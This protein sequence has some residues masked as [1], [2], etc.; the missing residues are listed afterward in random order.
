MVYYTLV[1]HSFLFIEL[2]D[3]CIWNY[4]KGNFEQAQLIKIISV[5]RYMLNKKLDFKAIITSLSKI[6]FFWRA[7]IPI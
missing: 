6:M 5:Y 1:D 4:Q 2:D 3:F 7:I